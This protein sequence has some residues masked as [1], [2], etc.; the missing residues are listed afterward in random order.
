MHAMDSQTESLPT[1]RWGIIGTGLISSWFTKDI[2]L[3]RRSPAAHHKIQAIGSS[4]SLTKTT[5]F[6]KTHLAHLSP[7]PK[8]Y[9]TYEEVYADP[10]VDIIYIG[11][12]HALHKAQC[13]SAIRAKKHVLCEKAFTL[14]ASE[15]REVLDAA[16]KEGVFVMEAMWTRFL[17]VTIALQKALHEER[18][19]GDVRR[20]FCDFGLDMQVQSLD[21]SSRLRDVRLGAGS[22]LDL[23][24]YALTWGFIALEAPSVKSNAEDGQ[25]KMEK[26]K[27]E[28]TATQV[29]QDGVDIASTFVLKY[30][31][32]GKIGIL[33]SSVEAKTPE[34]FMRIEG[35]EG[36]VVVEGVAASKPRAFTVY[37]KDS[38]GGG[39][40]AGAVEDEGKRYE[41]EV[42]GMGFH[43]EADAVAQSIFQGMRENEGMDHAETL[44]VMEMLDEIRAQGGARFPGEC[45]T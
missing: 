30:P 27:P 17:P 1:L 40:G 45:N 38:A 36:V 19:I 7:S 25:G 15:A 29:L 33:T 18:V 16:R 41:V 14:N 32:S 34:A 10:E 24:V 12:P 37:R 20:V 23:G 6:I 42:E 35:S 3:P 13:L 11:T 31:A 39:S 21:G 44:R 4:T 43:F 28:I 8:A 26:Q 2:T 5:D 22:L 9:G